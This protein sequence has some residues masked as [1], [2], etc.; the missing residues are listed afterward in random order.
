[1]VNSMDALD[2][3][4]RLGPGDKVSFRVLEDEEPAR[5]LS[6]MDSGE[7]EVPLL[8]RVKVTGLTCKSAAHQIRNVL[9]KDY[10][11]QASVIIG[12]DV[13]G[14]RSATRGKFYVGGCVRTIGY[15][16]LP[17]G[18]VMTVGKAILAA[19]GFAQYADKRKVK[20]IRKV[21]GTGDS[22]TKIVDLIEVLEKGKTSK[23]VVVEADD[24]ITVPERLFNF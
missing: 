18:E 21:S 5:S 17:V 13:M 23:D 19:G 9:L 1:M 16:N 3:T 6:V 14:V 12:L 24:I 20:I 2:D 4:Y 11:H 15:Q 10:Y 7:M 8:G 22:E